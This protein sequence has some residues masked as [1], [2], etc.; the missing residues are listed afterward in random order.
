MIHN[1]IELRYAAAHELED[2]VEEAINDQKLTFSARSLR[3]I[4]FNSLGEIA[5]AVERAMMICSRNGLAIREHFRPVYLSDN[6]T[7]TIFKDWK[8]SKLAYTLVIINGDTAN[9]A[10]ARLQLEMLKTYLK[11]N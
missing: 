9:C 1:I 7:H 5:S 11:E 4:G 3:D 8:M 2:A 10:V 6:S